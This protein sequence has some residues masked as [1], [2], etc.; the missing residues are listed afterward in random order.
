MKKILLS[1]IIALAFMT[2]CVDTVP[3]EEQKQETVQN[4]E[5]PSTENSQTESD[6]AVPTNFEFDIAIP[7]YSGEPYAVINNDIPYFTN[8]EMTTEGYVFL[9]ELDDLGRCGYGMMCAGK[10]TMPIDERGEIGM[11]KPTGWVQEKYPDVI[12]E[13]PSYL[14][15]R[16]HIL[17]WALSGVNADERGL[18]TGTRYLNIEGMFPNEET[19][20]DYI[21]ESG[22]HVMYRVTPFFTG[23]NL[24]A[25]GVLMEAKSVESDGIQFCRYAYNVQ[26]G[27][28]IDYA[29]GASYV[30]EEAPLVTENV[31]IAA[32]SY[33][34]NKNSM[35]FHKSD[36]F[37][38]DKMKP[39]NK[40]S[41]AQ[42]E[43]A[44]SNQY[45]PCKSCNP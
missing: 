26:P 27:I 31:S 20:V 19:I 5:H 33:I 28:T 6:S 37:S 24:L 9:S 25:D 11:I 41:F 8:E 30:S 15:N 21:E 43:E 14:Y 42:R 23:D 45:K 2:G 10:E 39:Q 32:E 35:V 4:E 34:G 13:S 36:C 44:V 18:I 1:L 40:V 12:K 16:A 29:T 3:V 7:A 22:E 38:V 17:M